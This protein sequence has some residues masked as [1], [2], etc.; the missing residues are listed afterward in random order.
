[1]LTKPNIEKDEKQQKQIFIEIARILP[2]GDFRL[3]FSETLYDIRK[4]IN[5]EYKN[6]KRAL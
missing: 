3:D 1:M 6:Q 5:F 4:L 2:N